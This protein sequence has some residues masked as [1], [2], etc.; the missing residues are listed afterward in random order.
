MQRTGEIFNP[1]R[2]QSVVTYGRRSREAA[3]V[4]TH[5]TDEGLAGEAPVAPALPAI[6]QDNTGK[7]DKQT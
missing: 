6:Y 3:A 1:P 2:K 7:L 5:R 4:M